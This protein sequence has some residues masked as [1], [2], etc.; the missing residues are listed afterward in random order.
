MPY[1]L[2]DLRKAREPK[3]ATDDLLARIP[4]DAPHDTDEALGCWNGERFVSW[5]E[6][7]LSQ[8]FDAFRDQNKVVTPPAPENHISKPPVKSRRRKPARR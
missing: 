7:I 2:D 8:P 4:P 6:W 1:S 5:K 3:P